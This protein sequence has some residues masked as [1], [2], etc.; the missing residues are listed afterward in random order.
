M[1]LRTRWRKIIKDIWGNK[2]R[3]LLVIL[4]I[5]VGVAAIGMI[6]NTMT[7]L[8]RDLF[9][10]HSRGN[11]ASVSLYISPFDTDLAGAVE[12]MR[13]VETVQAHR[14]LSARLIRAD[15]APAE[16]IT[17]DIVPGFDKVAIN[18]FSIERG[19]EIPGIRKILL[20]RCS[21]DGLGIDIGDTI[22]IETE[23][24]QRYSLTVSG[25]VHDLYLI[26]Y[27]ILG[28]ATGY[29][30]MDTL[31][32][33]GEQAYYSRL[34]V[35]VAENE[36]DREHALA[37]AAQARDRV[38]ETSGYQVYRIAIPGINSDPG[39]H[40]GQS[41]ING[42]V[43][44]LQVMSVLAI[45][46]SGGLV[47]NSISAILSQQIRQIGILRSIGA[48]RSQLVGMYVAN[49]LV[50]SVAGLAMGLPLGMLG[51]WWLTNFAAGYLNFD[52]TAITPDPTVTILQVAVG[53]VMPIVVAFFPIVSGTRISVYDAIYQQGLAGD[54][55]EG[56]ID[57]LLAKI[58]NL[59]PPVML[60]LRNT[61]RKKA[62]LA[63]T[64][65]TL[66]LAGAMF[67]S[68][69]STRASLTGQINQIARYVAFDASL[70]VTPGLTRA[71]VERTAMRIPGV[72]V[73][74]GWVSS[75]GILMRAD[76]SE[77]DEI[78]VY[79]I[80]YNSV[81]IDPLLIDGRWLQADD[82]NGVVINDDFLEHAPETAVGS[83]I[84]VKIADQN[85]TYEIVG[86]VS[87]HLSGSR[88][89]MTY[90]TFSKATGRSNQAD[91]V[92]V[93][94]DADKIG[95]S[96]EQKRL[97]AEIEDRFQD[98]GMSQSSSQTQ[99]EIFGSFTGPFDIILMVLVIMAGLLAVVGGLSL[100]G[101]MGMNVM[102]RTREIGVLRAVGANNQAV[103]QVV[104]IEGVV[105][106]L[107][108]WLLAV[109]VSGPAG[110]ALAGAVVYAVFKAPVNFQY[111]FE[112]LAIWLVV[113]VLIG[114]F[115]SLAPARSA[116]RLTVR[117]VLD[118]E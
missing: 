86:I 64:L 100:A 82:T 98:A 60:S 101:T 103:R 91:M 81:T 5:A 97:A 58:R 18:R 55:Q 54:R 79:G 32:W 44:V 52:V 99:D 68:V 53:L 78:Q 4:S 26:P 30:S 36:G 46:L 62:R 96:A 67:M 88:V 84:T 109:A 102:E 3:S 73:A 16:N 80:P 117:E 22:I 56:G 83:S 42:F 107:I 7:M 63:F 69:F 38:I 27:N 19:A 93:R 74:E 72:T 76:G 90:D 13:E 104:V 116:A 50:L 94:L 43:L 87:K 8:R 48:V 23:G 15:G 115:S 113:I 111:S 114:V 34:D 106:G 29:V 65:I 110:V 66:T 57:G 105:V 49:V 2:T 28:D 6:N 71:S 1:K 14:T 12:A 51:A 20:E 59:H 21:A 39:E 108:S 9:G 47:V 85:R 95:S 70:S 11:P 89:Y 75:G 77:G 112:G 40:W 17:L 24:K 92:R 10:A 33:M 35:I 41:Q 37:V 118:Y 25:I 31:R 61:F 45:F